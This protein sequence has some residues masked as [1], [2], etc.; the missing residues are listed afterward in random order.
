MR[1]RLGM[2]DAKPRRP[3]SLLRSPVPPED[4]PGQD[5]IVDGLGLILA[6]FRPGQPAI[7]G[8]LDG[9]Q[10]AHSDAC[11]AHGLPYAGRKALRAKAISRQMIERLQG[12]QVEGPVSGDRLQSDQHRQIVKA[13]D[14]PRAPRLP[15]QSRQNGALVHEGA[16]RP[17]SNQPVPAQDHEVKE[18]QQ[19]QAGRQVPASR[20]RRSEPGDGQNPDKKTRRA[21]QFAA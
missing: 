8:S 13:V 4:P 14:D 20:T 1:V 9:V 16:H 5:R 11:R 12:R 17:D 3:G 21:G 18:C 15:C 2:E 19:D 6:S 7:D 10:Y